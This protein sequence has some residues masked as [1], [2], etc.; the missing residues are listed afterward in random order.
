MLKKTELFA[1][2]S[3]QLSLIQKKVPSVTIPG[4]CQ[5]KEFISPANRLVFHILFQPTEGFGGNHLLIN[6]NFLARLSFFLGCGQDTEA[7]IGSI[8]ESVDIY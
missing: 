4:V 1:T 3:L 8:E 2:L 5:Y 7:P 6:G